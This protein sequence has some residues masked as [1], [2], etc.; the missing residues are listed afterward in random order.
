MP[1]AAPA[2]LPGISVAIIAL[3]E[4]GNLPRCL[5]SVAGL[6]DEVL[7]ADTGS[8]DE[9]V[10]VAQAHG[11][12]VLHLPWQGYADT[13]NALYTR[14]R[15][16]YILSLDADEALSPALHAA[17]LAL[18]PQLSGQAVAMPRLTN[19]CGHWV[20]HGGW[21]PDTKVRLFPTQAARWQGAYVHETLV[22]APGTPLTHVP[23]D[24]L[25]YSIGSIAQHLE[26][27]RKYSAL[28]GREL[29]ERGKRGLLFKACVSPPWR[30]FQMYV[31]RGGFRDGF[32]GWMIA[33]LSALAVFLKY[34]QAYQYRHSTP[35]HAH[36]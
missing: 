28:Q 31:L 24:L 30:F 15:H 18:K 6:A 5:A 23:A 35:P 11:A 16:Q 32:A 1:E 19:W 21:Y 20:R 14:A 4:A 33:R 34:T 36:P 27:V 9:T 2:L 8:T 10:A 25:H 13:K 7:V 26:T 22:L 12:R 17:L 29:A 3:N